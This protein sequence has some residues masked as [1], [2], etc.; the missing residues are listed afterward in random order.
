[1]NHFVLTNKDRQP[2][3][4]RLFVIILFSLGIISQA[5]AGSEQ[6]LKGVKS[7]ISRQTKS[8]NAL[9]NELNQ[10][11]KSLKSQE[12]SISSLNR[13]ISKTQ[14]NLTKA[15]ANMASFNQQK[16]ALE[17]KKKEQEQ[18]LSELLKTYYI[19]KQHNDVTPLL[20]PGE[21]E[22]QDRISQY[23]QHLAKTRAEDKE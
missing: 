13:E 14:Q 23:Y 1:M 3:W 7:E 5:Y 11:Q 15:K 8:V 6:E 12:L 2:I 22:Q 21:K 19:T 4:I 16:T 17:K 20:N 9:E 10:L 18:T